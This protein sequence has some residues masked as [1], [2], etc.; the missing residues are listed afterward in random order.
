[1]SCIYIVLNEHVQAANYNNQINS[2][3]QLLSEG[4]STNELN[5]FYFS[6]EA[7]FWDHYSFRSPET[8]SWF[9]QSLCSAIDKSN[10]D[11]SLL[12]I[13]LDVSR[14]VAVNKVSIFIYFI[15][16]YFKCSSVWYYGLWKVYELCT[17]K[18]QDSHRSSWY[19]QSSEQLLIDGEMKT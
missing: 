7:S 10:L 2:L 6:F 18:C 9:I 17:S 19:K 14:H 12:E 11:E 5:L 1:M 15:Y 16:V 13:L 8:G 4:I 3:S